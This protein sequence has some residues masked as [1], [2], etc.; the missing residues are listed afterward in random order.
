ME[1]SGSYWTEVREIWYLN[2]FRKSVEKIQYSLKSDT[3]NRYFTWRPMYILWQHVAKLFLRMKNCSDKSCR[4]NQNT[5]FMFSN[6]FFSR[7][8]CRLWD[9]LEKYGRQRQATDGNTTWPMCFACWIKEATNARSEYV[10][11][12]ACPRQ[13]WLGE[14]SSLLCLYLYCLT[15]LQLNWHK[16]FLHLLLLLVTSAIT[17]M[18]TWS[19][20]KFVLQ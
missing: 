15:C 20:D 9:N 6:F 8:S 12:I 10:I 19:A 2:I 7:K 11:F 3:D 14:C 13:Q 17:I 1:Q 5:N 4:E 18:L 16:P